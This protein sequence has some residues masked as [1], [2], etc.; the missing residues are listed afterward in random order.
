V[1]GLFSFLRTLLLALGWLI[2]IRCQTLR[3]TEPELR[4]EYEAQRLQLA[5]L[6]GE[7]IN[8]KR[9]NPRTNQVFWMLWTLCT[10]SV[11]DAHRL[12]VFHGKRT[13]VGWHKKAFKI[14]W[15]KKTRPKGRPQLSIPA[16]LL[17]WGLHKRN[18]AWS[19]GR[20]HDQLRYLNI[21]DVP[22]ENTI[23][24]YL[25]LPPPR[26]PR[27]KKDHRPRSEAAAK[28]FFGFLRSKADQAWG[29]DFFTVVTRSFQILYVLVIIH[30]GS[31]RII[32]T[33][34]TS[35]PY[36]FWLMQQFRDVTPFGEGPK[37]LLHD[38]DP[39]IMSGPFQRL[40]KGSNIT[41]IHTQSYAPWQNPYAER[42]IGGIRR[43]LLD[44]NLP[45]S[46]DHLE[47]LLKEFVNEYYNSE[48]THQGIGR[49]TP[50]PSKTHR[51]SCMADTQL[52]F[53]PILGGQY[54]QV[55]KVS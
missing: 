12:A 11:P 30:H 50:I 13:V 24:K 48:R 43:E 54:H 28:R 40:L 27:R 26:M 52:E 44:F 51:P 17:I 2:P 19:A 42:V 22:C 16:R 1:T 38:N 34:V 20:I 32:R 47:K 18:P 3:L 4:A 33:A 36:A 9:R 7:I 23:R 39:V 53:Q 49:T 31:R 5:L 6:K 46:R 21:I 35:Q 25:R 10:R 41:S 15:R 14:H 29:M 8:G 55:R 45:R 37:Y